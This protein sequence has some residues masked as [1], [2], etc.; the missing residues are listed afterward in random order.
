M[1]EEAQARLGDQEKQTRF[2]Y[3]TLDPDL[4]DAAQQAVAAG[5]ESVD[6]LLHCGS[7]AAA[8]PGR[9]AKAAKAS[10]CGATPPQVALIALD[11]HTGE[12]KALIGGRN[13]ATS[14]LNH[15]LAMRQ[16]GSVFKPFVY[17]AALET[18][19]TGGPRIFTPASV[20]DDSP[21]TFYFDRQTYQPS[22]FHQNFMGA[23]T[24][25]TALAH[26]LNVGT[27]QLAQK[28]GYDRVVQMAR[29]V[30]LERGD[31][32][33]AGG[34][35]GRVRDDAARDCRRIYGVRERGFACDADD[36]LTGAG[37][38]WNGS[39]PARSGPA[40]H[41]RSAR[42]LPDGQHDAGRPAGT[43]RAREFT[44]AASICRRRAR[45]ARPTMAGSPGSPVICCAWSGWAS[46]TIAS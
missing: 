23:V 28:V 18:A 43:A 1:N 11:P 30:G 33:H 27:V 32:A 31:Q 22:N 42:E 12:I 7:A 40:Q 13:Y 29:R 17:A 19:V 8:K 39:L 24:L 35:A 34:R 45:P 15:V 37:A 6:K 44:A 5:M 20:V 36:H 2:I 26:S 4:Q 16:P 38:G 9:G 21:T 41:A 10:G 3:S 14:Q 25:R 46:T